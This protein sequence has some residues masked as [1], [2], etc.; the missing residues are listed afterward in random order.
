MRIELL[1]HNL[2]HSD[3]VLD[4]SPANTTEVNSPTLVA[5]PRFSEVNQISEELYRRVKDDISELSL[6]M[7]VPE[8]RSGAQ[9]SLTC[10][11]AQVA[12]GIAIKKLQIQSEISKLRFREQFPILNNNG[13]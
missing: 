1:L 12:T 5:R 8:C 3:F 6:N 11:F 7:I 13:R 4:A 2:S 9:S 10:K